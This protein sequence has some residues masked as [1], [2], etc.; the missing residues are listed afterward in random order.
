MVIPTCS[1]LNL[2]CYMVCCLVSSL[3][4]LLY[5]IREYSITVAVQHN[6]INFWVGD[7]GGGI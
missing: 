7:D 1:E 6:V 2:V 5:L 3:D 4:Y